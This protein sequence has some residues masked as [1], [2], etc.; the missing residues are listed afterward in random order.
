MTSFAYSKALTTA[1]SKH[2]KG[3][4]VSTFPFKLIGNTILIQATIDDNLGYCILDSGSPNLILNARHFKN[5]RTE[6]TNFHSA[7]LTGSGTQ[8]LGKTRA[9]LEVGN[10]KRRNQEA[11]LIDLSSIEKSKKIDILG[12]I[13]YKF[14]KHFEV[15]LDF[16]QKEITLFGLDKGGERELKT[17]LHIHPAQIIDLKKSRHFL[18]L[19]ANV[20]EETIKLGLD[21]GA[22]KSILGKGALQKFQGNFIPSYAASLVSF[23]GKESGVDVGS[24]K[25]VFI[26]KIQLDH[27]EVMLMDLSSINRNLVT[28]LDGLL[29]NAFFSKKKIAINYK[30]QK[31]SIWDPIS[32]TQSSVR[33]GK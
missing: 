14:L 12:V 28:P 16:Q 30:K 17:P 29:G 33:I 10:I 26:G 3:P 4:L 20:N 21:C 2:Q 15:V 9:H 31:L 19:E 25:E 27:F 11:F 1:V 6:A 7:D 18:Y 24:V 5:K 23:N 8:P 22:E 32:R 13:G